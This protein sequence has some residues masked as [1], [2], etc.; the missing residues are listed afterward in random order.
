MAKALDSE[1]SNN[2]DL[3]SV[4]RNSR[5]P[6]Y[7]NSMSKD[8]T[9]S[10]EKC[11]MPSQN[12]RSPSR[13]SILPL[14]DSRI[15]SIDSRSSYDCYDS[16]ST[17]EDCFNSNNPQSLW[18]TEDPAEENKDSK[19]TQLKRKPYSMKDGA[20]RSRAL[21]ECRRKYENTEIECM[22]EIK[23]LRKTL[24]KNNEIQER[25]N[26]LLADFIKEIKAFK[27]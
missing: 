13:P 17:E 10:F 21:Y 4:P 3:L 14:T 9:P 2:F 24:N 19:Y 16:I 20:V 11:I 1:S 12:S 5:T 23:E 26:E 18:S 7:D 22:K 25:R 6:H 8:S 27:K 15:S